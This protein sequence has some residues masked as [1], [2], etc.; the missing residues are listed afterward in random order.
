ML[1]VPNDDHTK[2]FGYLG[3]NTTDLT[4]DDVA[5]RPSAALTAAYEAGGITKAS[6]DPAFTAADLATCKVSAE[7]VPYREE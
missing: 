7:G 5:V 6:G 2:L 4:N 3:D 1:A